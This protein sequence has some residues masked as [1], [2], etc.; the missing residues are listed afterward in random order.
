MTDLELELA[1]QRGRDFQAFTILL[2][3]AKN[4]GVINEEQ[5]LNLLNELKESL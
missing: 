4:K 5:F 1:K 2:H 3:E